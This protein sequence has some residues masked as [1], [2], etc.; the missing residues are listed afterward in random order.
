MTEQT[1]QITEKKP[2]TAI[3][4]ISQTLESGKM[5]TALE[6]SLSGTGRSPDRFRRQ[7]LIAIQNAYDPKR[8][9]N[10]LL[11][12]VSRQSLFLAIQ[13]AGS[14][15]LDLDPSLGH[16]AIVPRGGNATVSVMYR[17]LIALALRSA[18]IA[19][20]DF[21]RIHKNDE[22]TAR[23]GTSPL[24]SIEFDPLGDRGDVVGF[25]CLTTW[26]DG[27]MTYETLSRAEAQAHRQKHKTGMVWGADFDAMALKT[28]VRKEAKKWPI[29]VPSEGEADVVEHEQVSVIDDSPAPMR[30]VTPEA[31]GDHL[32]ALAG[33]L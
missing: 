15:G 29:E 13:Q 12:D 26:T 2:L 8:K 11:E 21:G 25:Y 32:D 33:S 28:V 16:M 30:D 18:K 27:A 23:R 5:A 14:T 22:V 6:A 19:A 31:G 24:L 9:K 10:P 3:Q 7:A 1:T 4:Q 17:G 20:I